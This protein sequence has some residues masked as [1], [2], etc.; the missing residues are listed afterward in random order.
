[1]PLWILLAL[2]APF[3]GS[4]L[5]VVISRDAGT[6]VLKGRSRCD[7]CGATLKALDL[8]PLVSWVILRRRCRHC[9][10]R[11][12]S[13]YPA[14]ELAALAPVLWAAILQ[15]GFLLI[16][17]AM[18][19]WLLIA[20][21]WID[22]RTYRLPDV[23]TLPLFALG[24]AGSW[25]FDRDNWIDHLIGAAA[26]LFFFAFIALL[27]RVVRRREG[28]GFGDAK[29]AA[30]LGAWVAWQGLPSVVSIAALSALAVAFIRE[31]GPKS[32][33]SDERLPF[34][35]FLAAGGWIVWLYGPMVLF[36]AA[37]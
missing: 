21:A 25:W 2:L 13:F 3:V 11:L 20:L 9:G 30:A 1:M 37:N 27:F 8:V 32:V 4:F 31:V 24:L 15:S 19:G 26:G 28:M 7:A 16:L 18:F 14:V 12:S 35:P 6:E 29:F 22:W 17:S 34:G 36:S 23:L 5:G 10:A 33:Q